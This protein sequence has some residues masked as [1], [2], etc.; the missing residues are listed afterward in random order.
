MS[1]SC[2]GRAVRPQP[3]AHDHT[4]VGVSVGLNIASGP[5]QVTISSAMQHWALCR[6]CSRHFTTNGC[7]PSYSRGTKRGLRGSSMR[8]LSHRVTQLVSRRGRGGG[9]G[10]M[11]APSKEFG[12]SS[13]GL[14]WWLLPGAHRT[15]SHA[16]GPP[17]TPEPWGL[18]AIRH[19]RKRAAL[20][21][22]IRHHNLSLDRWVQR[23]QILR[24]TAHAPQ[25]RLRVI[26]CRFFAQHLTER[27]CLV[28]IELGA[29]LHDRP[30]C[31]ER[32]VLPL[33]THEEG[34]TDMT[35]NCRNQ[36][37]AVVRYSPITVRL[38]DGGKQGSAFR[39]PHPHGVD[40]VPSG[41]LCAQTKFWSASPNVCIVA[42]IVL[43]GW[44]ALC[45]LHST[46]TV[47]EQLCGASFGS[48]S[49]LQLPPSL[50]P[51]PPCL[52]PCVTLPP[53]EVL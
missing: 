26:R 44:L 6:W 35:A 39:R 3:S 25:A 43:P 1:S 50:S 46:R 8:L 14:P 30:V 23:R 10:E 32:H 5:P 21:R 52:S 37:L 51:F 24:H 27:L 13:A 31:A 33:D 34:W 28:K 38:S 29:L 15:E 53:S 47:L 49:P 22:L 20:M 45:P 2:S 17:K 16:D 4:A 9:S 36:P 41:V 40:T 19:L 48:F 12:Q 11:G 42:L 7:Q 18:C